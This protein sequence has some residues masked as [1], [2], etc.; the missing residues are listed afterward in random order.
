MYFFTFYMYFLKRRDTVKSEHIALSTHFQKLLSG[1]M[2]D[3]QTSYFRQEFASLFLVTQSEIAQRGGLHQP[4]G[5]CSHC[6][7]VPQKPKERST[8][9][10]V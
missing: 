8:R 5:H 1:L 4:A 9:L 10:T 7:A 2:V 6:C 3:V